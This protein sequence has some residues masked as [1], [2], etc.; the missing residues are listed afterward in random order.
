VEYDGKYKDGYPDGNGTLSYSNGDVYTDECRAGEKRG[1]GVM[2][3]ANKETYDGEWENNLRHGTGSFTLQ[4]G[5]VIRGQWIK[6][7]NITLSLL[8]SRKR[9]ANNPQDNESEAQPAAKRPHL[10]ELQ[11][12]NAQLHKNNEELQGQVVTK[13]KVIVEKDEVIKTKDDEIASLKTMLQNEV[14]AKDEVIVVNDEIIKMKDD[15][16][17]SMKT[18][19]QDEIVAK[20]KVIAEKDEAIA[21]KDA[22]LTSLKAK[23]KK[24]GQI[25][26]E[27]DDGPSNQEDEHDDVHV[28][29][30][31]KAKR[32]HVELDEEH[33]KCQICFTKFSTDT[34]NQDEDIRHLLPVSSESCDH[35]FCLGCITNQQVSIAEG[36]NNGR[37]PKWIECM[38]CKAKT[39]F[40]PSKPRYHRL[41]IDFLTRAQWYAQPVEVKEED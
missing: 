11:S 14:V 40:C 8:T 5:D 23:L 29:E 20:D 6:D 28:S 18:T 15:E 26:N 33:T 36:R 25:L 27:S 12:T 3:Y 21:K 38:T 35:Y 13:D 31:P 22:E 4:N 41:L 32:P 10:E 34:N 1:K 2:T 9:A 39:A 7:K 17:A 30:S 19:M 37:V 16:F 24:L